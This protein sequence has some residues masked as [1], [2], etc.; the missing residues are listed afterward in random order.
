MAEVS[1]EIVEKAYEAVEIAKTTGKIKKG[2]NE[3]TKAVERGAAKLVLYA[4]DVN[5]P[6]VIMHLGPLCKDKETP[7][8]QVESREELG[9][10]AGLQVATASVVIIEEGESKKLIKEIIDTLGQNDTTKK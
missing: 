5:P 2:I 3:T 6:E 1:K 9:T 10:A 7:C 4:K 8:I